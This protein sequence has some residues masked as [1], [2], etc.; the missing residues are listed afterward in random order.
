M[1]GVTIGEKH[2]YNDFGMILMNKVISPPKP[3]AIKVDVPMRDGTI[4]LTGS[5]SDEVKFEDRKITLTFA[6]VDPIK[7]WSSKVSEFEN[8]LHGKRLKV[9][10]D[11]DLSFYYIGRVAVNSWTSDK[12]LGKLVVECVVEPFKYDVLSSA[13]DW[14]WDIF[15]FEEGIINDTGELI[16]N[17]TTT[18]KLICRRK[19]MYPI[20]T[21]SAAMTLTYD[22]EVYNLTAGSQR[23][24]DLFLREGENELTFTGN[25]TI[26]IDY[27]G[28]SL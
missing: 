28:G 27:I 11:D 12:R 16:V 18:I 19:R 8:Y 1:Y 6:V 3:R 2:S 9:I 26:S 25:G 7:T 23:L 4:D 5:L 15:D 13:V 24:Y 20:I 14:E 22:G 10:F 17:G 21:A